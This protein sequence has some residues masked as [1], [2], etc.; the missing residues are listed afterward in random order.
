MRVR[1]GKKEQKDRTQQAEKYKD[2]KN[3][4]KNGYSLEFECFNTDEGNVETSTQYVSSSQAPEFSQIFKHG[5][6]KSRQIKTFNRGVLTN[7]A[8]KLEC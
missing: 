1:E 7:F 5:L 8:L 4:V 6:L 3:C 2:L